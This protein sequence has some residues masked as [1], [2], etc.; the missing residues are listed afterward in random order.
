VFGAVAT[1]SLLEIA[2]SEVEKTDPT[3]SVLSAELSDFEKG[4][5]ADRKEKKTAKQNY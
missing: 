5:K 4:C 2:A 3:F 1:L